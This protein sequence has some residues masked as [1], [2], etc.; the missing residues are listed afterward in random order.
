MNMKK[1]MSYDEAY[2]AV[3]SAYTKAEQISLDY[4]DSLKAYPVFPLNYVFDEEKSVRWN[5]EEGERRAAARKQVE[6]EYKKKDADCWQEAVNAIRAFIQDEYGFS[7]KIA[8]L[9][10][11]WAYHKG[12]AY[13]YHEVLCEAQIIGEQV[14][15]FID[16]YEQERSKK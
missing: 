7:E 8:E 16:T 9:V 5:R 10:Y 15:K 6:N 11:D 14:R 3:R 4:N 2:A 13:G 1:E 12:H